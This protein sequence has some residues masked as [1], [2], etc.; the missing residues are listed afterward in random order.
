MTWKS[1]FGAMALALLMAAPALAETLYV[2]DELVITVRAQPDTRAEIVESLRTGA[3]VEVLERPDGSDF[4]RVRTESGIEGWSLKQYLTDRPVARAQLA[5]AQAALRRAN[6]QVEALR[7]RAG[8]AEAELAET[9]EN[10]S[11]ATSSSTALSEEL[12][13]LREISGSAVETRQE[14]ERATERLR[15]AD[16][17]VERLLR[18]NDILTDESRRRWFL[19]GGGVLGAGVI[20]GLILPSLRRKKRW[21]W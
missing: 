12:A 1:R 10:L 6:Q 4:L 13:E 2:V 20:L 16:A 8:A 5:E 15:M 18:E 14:L 19:I 11:Q 3:S 7:K 17:E 9:R 21:D